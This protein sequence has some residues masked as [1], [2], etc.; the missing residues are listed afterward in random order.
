MDTVTLDA[1]KDRVYDR[2]ESNSRFYQESQ[3]IGHIND[4]IRVVNLFTGFLEATADLYSQD[5][6]L[7]YD[8]PPTILC[9]TKVVYDG[10]DLD[11][12]TFGNL[13]YSHPRWMK[14]TTSTNSSQVETWTPAGLRKFICH[15]APATGGA[16]VS[17]TGVAEPVA[18]VADTD[19]ITMQREYTDLIVDHASHVP[20]IRCGGM[21]A[22]SA[23][24][25]YKAFLGRMKE[26][27]R[28]RGKVAPLFRLEVL[29]KVEA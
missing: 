15:P 3:I 20:M 5:G 28:F 18:L 7:I 13:C 4:A 1:L 24:E 9:L 10:R 25:Q 8:V 22:R 27:S 19:T 29:Q 16:V 21:V 14:E 12:L 11:K 26:L 2:L 17:L 6:R 23:M